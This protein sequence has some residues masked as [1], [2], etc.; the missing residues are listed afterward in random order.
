MQI[1]RDLWASYIGIPACETKINSRTNV[2][3]LITMKTVKQLN[4]PL[5][6]DQYYY[7]RGCVHKLYQLDTMRQ[8]S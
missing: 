6:L 2:L 7:L 3:V 4:Q 5:L 1:F 8:S